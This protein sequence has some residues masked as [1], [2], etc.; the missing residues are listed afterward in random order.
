MSIQIILICLVAVS[1]VCLISF[2][3]WQWRKAEREY[4]ENLLND[5]EW[6]EPNE[7]DS[8]IQR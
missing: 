7:S 3:S 8:N 2:I 4:F 6:G 1:P 5:K